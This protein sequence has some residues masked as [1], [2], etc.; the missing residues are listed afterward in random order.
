MDKDKKVFEIKPNVVW[1]SSSA[2]KLTVNKK[3]IESILKK[4]CK[5]P[6][7]PNPPPPPEWEDVSGC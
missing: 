2:G 6:K 7:N 1:V 4:Y 3:T 5:S